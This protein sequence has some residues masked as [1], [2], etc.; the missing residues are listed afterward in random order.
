[1]KITEKSDVYSYGVVLLEVLTGKQPN[2]CRIPEAAHIVNWV[3]GELQRKA[4]VHLIDERLKG[5]PDSETQEMVQV[6][7]VALLCVSRF[8]QERPTMRDVVAMLK[9]I[10]QDTADYSSKGDRGCVPG[11]CGSFSKSSE[12][13]ITTSSLDDYSS[14]SSRIVFQ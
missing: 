10:K 2:D 13:L 6:L 12:P 7:G 9:E 11:K 3:Q 1:M 4:G 5:W 14:C 8:P